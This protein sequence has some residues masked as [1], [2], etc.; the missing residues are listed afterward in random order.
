MKNTIR[1]QKISYDNMQN[2][3]SIL[4]MKNRFEIRSLNTPILLIDGYIYYDTRENKTAHYFY[5][6]INTK[7][8]IKKDIELR[9]FKDELIK[10]YK[11][12]I[13]NIF[14]CNYEIF[15]IKIL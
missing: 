1:Y 14:I 10:K 8:K 5:G 12:Y 7:N 9:A 15:E 4:D 13:E 6:Y 3:E 11:F 2:E